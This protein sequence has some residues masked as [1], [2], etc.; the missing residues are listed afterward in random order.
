MSKVIKIKK[1]LDI[2]LKGAAEKVCVSAD[3]AS[4]FAVKPPDY[5]GLTPKMLLKPGEPVKVGT[6]LFFDKYNPEVKFT[7]PVA[8]VLKSV[9]RGERRRILEVV[10]EAGSKEE[11]V[12]LKKGDPSGMGEDDVRKAILESGLW[13]SLIQRP[14]GIIAD[15]SLKPDFIYISGFDTAPL[16]PDYDLILK[17]E[18]KSF[19]TGIEALKKLCDGKIHLG[20]KS[21]FPV[22]SAFADL[23]GV[24]YHYFS[25]PHPAGNAGI[26]INHVRPIN[27]GDVVWTI[28][29]QH[30][31]LIGKLFNEGHLVPEIVV[32]LSG[33]KVSKPKYY[34]T[35][36]GTSISALVK[37]NLAGG[38]LKPRIISGNVLTGTRIDEDG[39]LGYF[40]SLVS[41]IPEGDY[42]EIFGWAMPGLNKFSMSKSFF[43]WMFPNRKWDIDTNI[44]GGERAFVMS[45]QY[46]KV[47]PMDI[48]P[49]QLLKA[50][51]VE[52]IDRM[53]Q[54][55]IYEVLEEDF[56][57]CEFVCTSKIETQEI[58]RNGLDLMRKEMS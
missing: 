30:V 57:L 6:P 51:L 25:G 35:I 2:K 36:A 7:S 39:Y 56:A 37:G 58:L 3:R 26:Q 50:I 1:G 19:A 14:Y 16:A 29:P 46:E 45:G 44:K 15:P 21:G 53:E 38:D 54:L 5:V 41:V 4:L 20:L 42:Y 27:K 10:I 31:S 52:D 12:S 34:R 40:D 55:G 24:E 18:Q 23:P 22:A 33:S 49:V 13:P 17:D 11:F 32:A 8:G 47:L 48:L 28:N 9:N 43:S